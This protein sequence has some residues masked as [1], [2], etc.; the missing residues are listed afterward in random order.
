[1]NMSQRMW[2][3]EQERRRRERMR[4]AK[5]RRNCLAAVFIAAVAAV[6]LIVSKSCD[7]GTVPLSESGAEPN[8]PIETVTPVPDSPF[9]ASVDISE[10]N[11]S[12]FENSVFLGNALAATI[13]MYNLLPETD[14]YASVNLD[15][16]NV[17]TTSVG[18]DST[19]AADQLKS[20][21]FGRVYLCFGENELAWGSASKFASAYSKLIKKV[22]E[23][24]PGASIYLVSIPPVTK[25]ASDKGANGADME[26]IKLYN[27]KIR[28]LAYNEKLYYVD[29]VAA[30]GRNGGYINE[31][32][33]ADGINLNREYVIELLA[34]TSKKAYI[35]N[36]PADDISEKDREDESG[37][38]TEEASEAPSETNTPATATVEPEP[39]VNVLK[40]SAMTDK[41]DR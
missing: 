38:V 19:A 6:V 13:D 31:G 10:I 20:T 32:T 27:R 34:A 8:K 36:T 29:S 18:Y 25:S 21:K 12:V 5:R 26:T 39:T 17:Y 2:R 1:M 40:D 11:L 33:S 37:T 41:K 35:P 3:R 14:F 30:L 9:K 7:S 22:K 24:Q 4:R 16:E 28:N 15:L 23:Y